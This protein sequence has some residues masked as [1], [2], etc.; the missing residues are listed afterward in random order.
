MIELAQPW[1][2][3]GLLSVPVL[4]ALHSL[5]P[6]RRNLEISSS[7]LWR[8]ALEERR[9]GFG[10]RKLLRDASLLALLLL[11][12]VL[13][14]ALADPRWVTRV[15]ED[16][17]VV[18]VIDA[19]ASMQTRDGL[20][21]RF[22]R[23]RAAAIAVVDGLPSAARVLV[24]TSAREPRLRSG[25]ESDRDVLRAL[26][27]GLRPTDEAGRPRD[28][29]ALALSL[30]RNRERGR[31]HLVTDA[32]F[33]Q[34][35]DLEG[36][37]LEVHRVGAAA[38]N[39]AITRFDVRP[40]IWAE[41]RFQIL[42]RLHNYTDAPVEVPTRITLGDLSVLERTVALAAGGGQTLVLPFTGNASGV[43]RASIDTG[44]DLAVDDTAQAVLAAER[45]TRVL[46]VG[47]G[48]FYLESILAALP[49]VEVNRRQSVAE[50]ELAG[51][52]RWHDVVVLDRV[53]TPALPRGN[54]LLLDTVPPGLPFSAD[55]IVTGPVVEAVGASALVADLDLLSLRIEQ[56]RRIRIAPDAPGLQRLFWSRETTLGLAHIDDG[57]RL[58]Y[59]G[60]DPA[61]SSFP[62]QAAFPLFVSQV[63][64]WLGPGARDALPTQLATGEA[65][66]VQ[67]PSRVDGATVVTPDGERLRFAASA[68]PFTFDRTSRAGVYRLL[69]G[70]LEQAF[71]VNLDDERESDVTPRAMPPPA[72]RA[73]GT[74]GVDSQ[75]SLAI[76]P[77]LA[78]AAL[79]LVLLEWTLWC[80]GRRRG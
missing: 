62:L 51:E 26:I 36:A 4:I 11:A 60:F 1:A 40:E 55:G 48:S 49:G 37:P 3:L 12:V 73:P 13:S 33:D 10:L 79:A 70:P 32:A 31:V 76:W 59:L 23:A 27:G 17:D 22:D 63:M 61:R 8:E 39:V 16:E 43:A 18:L 66:S 38:R 15:A 6:S 30:L 58:V 20:G 56:G 52:A 45:T 24:M 21:T 69:A 28:A 77:Y 14:V 53:E 57:R 7:L 34:R 44:D 35:L 72:P 47:A 5:R 54:F 50:H 19:S 68:G 42:L 65:F 78:M 75:V 71:A 64:A 25:F 67:L 2:L 29:V 46:L 41:D 9:R 80:W 74:S